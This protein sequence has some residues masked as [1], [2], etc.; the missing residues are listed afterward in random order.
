MLIQ[1]L[2]KLLVNL[3][4]SSLVIEP[5]KIRCTSV[6]GC[7]LPFG[8][9]ISELLKNDINVTPAIIA[10]LTKNSLKSTWVMFELGASWALGKRVYIMLGPGL[11]PRDL[12]GPLE[13]HNCILIEDDDASANI[14]DAV[15]QISLQLNIRQRTGG[16][17][18]AD[19]GKFVSK[20]RESTENIALIG[21]EEL[22]TTVVSAPATMNVGFKVIKRETNFHH[23]SLTSAVTLNQ[24]PDQ[25]FFR[26]SIFWPTS[27]KIIVANGF[28]KSAESEVEIDGH[29]YKEFAI[30][31]D[32]R[33]WPEQ[34][35]KVIDQNAFA[36]LE[37]EI[38]SVPGKDF[39]VLHYT[40]F[41]QSWSPVRGTIPFSELNDF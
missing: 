1:K 18:Q 16:R 29:N 28:E 30:H 11:I 35:I 8:H 21:S 9:T 25:D 6:Q 12:K 34:T 32:K 33:L 20:F 38:C 41:L 4:L 26:V 37:Y 7:K 10:L 36:Q 17:V 40:I 14:M 3:I 22:R 15:K 23:Y 19:L 5:D 24:I 39:P 27:I 13:G 2:L 31:V